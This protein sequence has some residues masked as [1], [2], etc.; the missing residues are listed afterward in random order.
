VLEGMSV[1]FTSI[2]EWTMREG[3]TQPPFPPDRRWA[4]RLRYYPA[5]FV[6]LAVIGCAFTYHPL[7]A[8]GLSGAIDVYYMFEHTPLRAR[9]WLSA[10]SDNANDG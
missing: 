3:R 4:A 5:V 8:L 10:W 6:D 1:G 2:L 7:L 9:G